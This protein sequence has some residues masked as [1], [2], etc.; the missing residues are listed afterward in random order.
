MEVIKFDLKTKELSRN[1]LTTG[2]TKRIDCTRY[3]DAHGKKSAW[4]PKQYTFDE[5]KKFEIVKVMIE[6]TFPCTGKHISEDW[7]L[8][9]DGQPLSVGEIMS[10]QVLKTKL[11]LTC[12]IGSG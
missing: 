9:V 4:E 1:L 2:Y 6:T 8:Y 5:P 7:C 10:Y 12:C 3:W 11:K